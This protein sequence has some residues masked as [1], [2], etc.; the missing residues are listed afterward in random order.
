[1]VSELVRYFVPSLLVRIV[2]SIVHSTR[3]TSALSFDLAEPWAGTTCNLASIRSI[4]VHTYLS[5]LL[6]AGGAGYATCASTRDDH[7][8]PE[9]QERKTL[10]LPY[11]KLQL[12]ATVLRTRGIQQTHRGGTQ[13]DI[14]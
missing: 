10:P 6:S 11:R 13:H 1:M 8:I 2:L 7:A 4:D 12:A 5:W 9:R 14:M 3:S